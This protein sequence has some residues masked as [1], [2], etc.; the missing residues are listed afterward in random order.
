MSRMTHVRFLMLGMAHPFESAGT[1]GEGAGS[2][3]AVQT[4][5]D[6]L[7]HTRF[8]ELTDTPRRRGKD[9]DVVERLAGES[10]AVAHDE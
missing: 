10:G 6:I 8:D 4:A 2:C 5:R 7:P 3:C 1:G 9:I